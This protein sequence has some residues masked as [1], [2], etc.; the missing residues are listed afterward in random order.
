MDEPMRALTILLALASTVAAPCAPA[1]NPRA[2]QAEFIAAQGLRP[3]QEILA[4]VERRYVGRVISSDVVPG[5]KHE[6]AAVAYEIRLLTEKGAVIRLRFDAATGEFLGADG[7]GL[8][9][10]QRR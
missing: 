7:R 10:A 6:M 2:L 9:D 3:L 5:K 4:E 1:A 8:V